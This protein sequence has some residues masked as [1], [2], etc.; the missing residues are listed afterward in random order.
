[1]ID[2]H[3]DQQVD[4]SRLQAGTYSVVV[5]LR[6]LIYFTEKRDKIQNSTEI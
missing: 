3:R 2:S 4:C 6:H 5:V 1:M